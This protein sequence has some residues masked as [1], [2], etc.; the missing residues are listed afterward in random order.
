MHESLQ[1]GSAQHNQHIFAAIFGAL[2]QCRTQHAIRTHMHTVERQISV[3]A[4]G[5]EG[6][7]SVGTNRSTAAIKREGIGENTV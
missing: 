3:D 7:S 1:I 2:R 4:K 6:L 5:Y